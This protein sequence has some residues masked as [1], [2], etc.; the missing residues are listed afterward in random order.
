MLP[1]ER[2]RAVTIE[3][4]LYTTRRDSCGNGE[5]I[6]IDIKSLI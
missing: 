6:K 5:I 2:I 1:H 3:I 4:I